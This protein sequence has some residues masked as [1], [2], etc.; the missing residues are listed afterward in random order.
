MPAE[1]VTWRSGAVMPLPEDSSVWVWLLGFGSEKSQPEL[2]SQELTVRTGIYAVYSIWSCIDS[3]HA[4]RYRNPS[5]GRYNSG[6]LGTTP[7]FESHQQ[8]KES[9][10]T[11]M[12][13][14][15]GLCSECS[16]FRSVPLWNL[17]SAFQ[18]VLMHTFLSPALGICS[19]DSSVMYSGSL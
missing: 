3:F 9:C 19:S 18:S 7:C 5:A 17:V 15:P 13:R 8:T 10:G 16:G 4:R 11:I 6:S 2:R 14:C 12:L 1:P